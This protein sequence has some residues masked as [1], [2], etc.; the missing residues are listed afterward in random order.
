MSGEREKC[1]AAG[2]DDYMAKPL[3]FEALAHKIFARLM[4]N[5]FRVYGVKFEIFA[6]TVKKFYSAS[7]SM[8]DERQTIGIFSDFI[9]SI[10]DNFLK[11]ENA[12]VKNDFETLEL[13]SHRL[14]GLSGTL[15]FD[16]LSDKMAV[17]EEMAALK[18]AAKCSEIFVEIK[19]M[20][21]GRK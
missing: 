1:L 10:D 12:M 19:N 2:M 8:L 7:S 16:T 6:E 17:I 14:K 9:K 4:E 13:L 3:N 21:T 15:G 11:I 18:Q 5:A 20:L